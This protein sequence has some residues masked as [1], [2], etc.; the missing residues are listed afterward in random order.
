MKQA[1]KWNTVTLYADGHATND[2][3]TVECAMREYRDHGCVTGFFLSS[4]ETSDGGPSREEIDFTG[5]D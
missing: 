2:R 5:L 1:T 3:E 4:D